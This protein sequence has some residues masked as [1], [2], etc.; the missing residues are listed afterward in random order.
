MENCQPSGGGITASFRLGAVVII[1]EFFLLDFTS[2]IEDYI[3]LS[4]L[5][6][7]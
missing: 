5:R 1:Q 6:I 4:R 2:V 3:L 7:D